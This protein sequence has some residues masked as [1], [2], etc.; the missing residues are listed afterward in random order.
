[1]SVLRR[2]LLLG[3]ALGRSRGFFDC[4]EAIQ[5]KNFLTRVREP[6]VLAAFSCLHSPATST[7]RDSYVAIR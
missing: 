1:M 4:M 2:G 7:G 3:P 6:V 5:T